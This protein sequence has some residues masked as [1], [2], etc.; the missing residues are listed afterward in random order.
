MICLIEIQDN[1][2]T[3]NLILEIC[4]TVSSQDQQCEKT[5]KDPVLCYEIYQI[6]GASSCSHRLLAFN[7]CC[8]EYH[9]SCL[10]FPK[11][12][13]VISGQLFV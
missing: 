3:I 13:L 5:V 10:Y 11:H 4:R 12:L 7:G 6:Y 8:S 2:F 1:P 9:T